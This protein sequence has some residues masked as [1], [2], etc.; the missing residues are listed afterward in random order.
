MNCSR[1]P[2]ASPQ[3]AAA[4]SGERHEPLDRFSRRPLDR[5]LDRKPALVVIDGVTEA[6]TLHG[7]DLGDNVEI[8]RWL[9]LLPRPAARCGVAVLLLDHV[10]KDKEALS[11]F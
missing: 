9:E 3:K 5:T 4:E 11:P 7:F 10:V 1:R 2:P 6:L 8:A